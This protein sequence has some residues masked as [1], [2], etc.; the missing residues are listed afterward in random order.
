MPVVEAIGD[1]DELYRRL[2]PYY[3]KK[4]GTVSSAAYK[5]RRGTPENSISVDLARLTTAEDS[6]ARDSRGFRLGGILAAVPREFDLTV[7]HDPLPDNPAHSL[8]EGENSME[9]CYKLAEATRVVI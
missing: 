7:H 4:D 2:F 5:D 9:T 3:V 8:I 1:E 6:V